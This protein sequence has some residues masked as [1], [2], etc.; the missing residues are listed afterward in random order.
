[1]SSFVDD[2]FALEDEGVAGENNGDSP[3]DG[4]MELIIDIRSE[5]R[6]NKDWGTSDKIRDALQEIGIVLKDSKE[7]TSW[8]KA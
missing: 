6:A 2:I 3:M 8:T 7:G 5:A 1:M 4:L